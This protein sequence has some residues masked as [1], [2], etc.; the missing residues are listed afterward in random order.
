MKIFLF[1]VLILFAYCQ[2]S[3]INETV[4]ENEYQFFT[5]LANKSDVTTMIQEKKSFVLGLFA[6]FSEKSLEFSQ[7]FDSVAKSL[8]D[9]EEYEFIR[10][11]FHK[12]DIDLAKT[13][14]FLNLPGVMTIKNGQPDEEFSG[15]AEDFEIWIKKKFLAPITFIESDKEIEE[16]KNNYEVVAFAEISDDMKIVDLFENIAKSELKKSIVF[17]GKGGRKSNRLTIFRKADKSETKYKGNFEEKEI[18]EWLGNNR[19]PF[20]QKI[21]FE[22]FK[23]Y[24]VKQQLVGYLFID[25]NKEKEEQPSVDLISQLNKDFYGKV[26]FVWAYSKDLSAFAERHSITGFPGIVLIDNVQKDHYKY[27]GEFKKK[28]I[29]NWLNDYFNGKIKKTIKKQPI[30]E[31][32]D[33]VIKTVVY[34]NWEEI[35]N[36]PE[37]DVLMLIYA[38]WC[39]HCKELKPK[40][41]KLAEKLQDST[42]LIFAEIDG[43]KNDI[44]I[45][46]TLRGY[47]TIML[48]PAKNKKDYILYEEESRS[49]E[50]LSEFL[51]DNCKTAEIIIKEV[52]ENEKEEDKK[53]KKDKKEKEDKKDK[54]EKEEDKKK[55]IKEL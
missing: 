34:D 4:E 7:Q 10:F 52:D 2:E 25:F 48:F 39:K 24:Y 32:N 55:P 3:E 8:K 37:N 51:N 31:S 1:I 38:D 30:P 17:V 6:E 45:D 53:D 13:L 28:D 16:F 36:D 33:E 23:D 42:G 41:K 26:S 12:E 21:S 5:R 29:K 54:K 15:E 35:V 11:E 18:I 20:I 49:I 27:E 9:R 44:K 46:I 43:D 40:Y 22:N 47:P 14:G 19:I 50:S